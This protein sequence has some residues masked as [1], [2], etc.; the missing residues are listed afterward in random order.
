MAK[1]EFLPFGTAEGANVLSNQEYEALA[2]R[3]N[4]FNS[5]VAKSKELN[6]VWRQASLIA[7]AVAQFIVDTDQKD[8][9][10]TGD[11]ADIKSRLASVIN[12]I[13]SNGDYV[14][15]PYLKLE[16]LKKIDKADIAQQLGNDTGK[17]VSQNLLTTELG[18]KAGVADVNGKMAKDQNGADIPNK[19]K[20]IENLGLEERLNNK[21][22]KTGGTING[23]LTVNRDGAAIKIK[24]LAEGADIRFELIN[25]DGTRAGFLGF[26]SLSNQSVMT[27]RNDRDSSTMTLT[28]EGLFINNL[29]TATVADLPTANFGAS[30]W[31]KDPVTGYMRQ[32]M[33]VDTRAGT[34]SQVFQFP[35]PFPTAV[36]SISVALRSVS[37][38]Y[39]GMMWNSVSRTEVNLVNVSQTTEASKVYITAEGY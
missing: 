23:V 5:G 37:S 6:K 26:P 20:F 35:T 27:L 13:I 2:A 22:D 19:S 12:L 10:D 16:L 7:S 9:L 33:L 4:G 39:G 18:K 21:L 8:L 3:H 36:R 14:T 17:V 29:K 11:V 24:A 15:N 38:G 30:G 28:S 34:G 31:Y 32:W 1:N 25:S